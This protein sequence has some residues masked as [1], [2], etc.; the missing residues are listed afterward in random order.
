MK[1]VFESEK[2]EANL[3]MTDEQVHSATNAAVKKARYAR[4][5]L[6]N[7]EPEGK[8]EF[9]PLKV[10]VMNAD[11]LKIDADEVPGSKATSKKSEMDL[12]RQSYENKGM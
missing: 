4:N 5:T 7:D 9:T 10:K 1:L 6:A 8:I 2:V 12:I 11:S 3:T